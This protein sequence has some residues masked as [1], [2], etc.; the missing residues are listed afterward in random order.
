MSGDGYF[1]VDMTNED[2]EDNT[3]YTDRVSKLLRRMSVT[4]RLEHVRR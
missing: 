3:L 2:D 4:Q 1:L